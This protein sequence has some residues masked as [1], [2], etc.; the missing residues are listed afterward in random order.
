MTR[1]VLVTG[2]TSGIG[3][4][5]AEAFAGE[6]CQVVVTG[7][8]AE[9]A[10]QISPTTGISAR[11]LD[12]TQPAQIAAII[13]DMQSLDVLVNAAGIILRNQ[14][15]HNPEAFARVIDVNLNGAMRICAAARPLLAKTRGCVI[16][17]ASMLSF[18]GSGFV[19]AYSASKGGIAQ[20]TKSLSI[21]WAAERIR[22][23]A[24]AP[25]WI[26]TAMTAPLVA[27]SE[28][29]EAIVSRTPLGRWGQPADIAG[30][31]L[32]LASPGAAFVT[33]VILPVDGGYSIA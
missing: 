18:F 5:I 30:A 10:A 14:Q 28:R 2:G 16:N 22:V 29:R 26:E 17:I 11:Q 9:E 23:N 15:E 21:A 24:I 31:A 20:L 1:R 3:W 19:P 32:F 27:D 13:A 7:R 4:A 25:G 6:G 8:T 33:G 12:V